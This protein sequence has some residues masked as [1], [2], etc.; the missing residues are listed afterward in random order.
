MECAVGSSFAREPS[1]ARVL[2]PM[3]RRRHIDD[4]PVS[5]SLEV[6]PAFDEELPQLASILS[7][8]IPGILAPFSSCKSVHSY[9]KSIYSVRKG[10]SI[11]GCFACLHLNEKGLDRLLEG[12]LSMAEPEQDCLAEAGSHVEAIYAW[13][14]AIRPPTN[15][16]RAIGNFMACLRRPEF[17][18]A[19]IYGRPTTDK[20][21]GFAQNLDFR[22]VQSGGAHQGLWVTARFVLA[23]GVAQGE[24][25]VG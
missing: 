5:R 18:S 11:V 20:G 13:A 15:G 17:C 1:A 6:R 10:S 24:C 19:E 21:F 3:R 22:P 9:S 4:I 2:A 23:R 14:W 12:S 7:A 25:N 16:V 8:L